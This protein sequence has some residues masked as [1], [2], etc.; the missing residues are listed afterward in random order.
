MTS[1][2]TLIQLSDPHLSRAWPF[3]RGNWRRLM[4]ELEALRPDAIVVSGDLSVDGA[5]AEEDLALAADEIAR[6]P[7]PLIKAICGNHDIGEPSP[8]NAAGETIDAER[9][10]RFQRHFGPEWWEAELGPWVLLGINSMLPG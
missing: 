5:S 2:L 3:F 4:P 1:T 7:A 9:R 10:A 6:L 8:E